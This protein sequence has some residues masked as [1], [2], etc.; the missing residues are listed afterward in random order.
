VGQEDVEER[1]WLPRQDQLQEMVGISDVRGLINLQVIY[2]KEFILPDSMEKLWLS[3]YMFM[4]YEKY[5]DD[6]E[7]KWLLVGEEFRTMEVNHEQ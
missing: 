2:S 3:I 1:V 6:E 7:K 4:K 5:F